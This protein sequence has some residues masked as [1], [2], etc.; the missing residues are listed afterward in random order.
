MTTNAVRYRRAA[1]ADKVL[2]DN[3]DINTLYEFNYGGFR[4]TP[5]AQRPL[6]APRDLWWMRKLNESYRPLFA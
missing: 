3:S 6:H 1:G 2:L 5:A 4:A